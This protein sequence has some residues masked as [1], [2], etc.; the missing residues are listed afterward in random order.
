MKKILGILS[1]L[2]SG[3][4]QVGLADKLAITE[5]TLIPMEGPE[6][7]QGTILI[8]DGRIKAIK[9]L[10]YKVDGSYRKISAQGKFVIPGLFDSHIHFFQSGGLYT[11]PDGVDFRF[12]V[13]YKNQEFPQT[14]AGVDTTF[15]RYLASGV[16]SVVDMGG[17]MENFKVR[18]AARKSNTAPQVYVAGPLLST[19]SRDAMDVGDKP[20]VKVSNKTEADA[21][22]EKLAAQKPDFIKIWY[23][24]PNGG[25]WK[26]NADLVQ[27]IV[28]KSHTLGFRVA[29]HATELETARAAV[30]FGADVLVHSVEDK[31][32]DASFVEL[33][34]KKAV[35]YIPTLSVG[36]GYDKTF[37]QQISFSPLD[38][39]TADPFKMGTLFDLPQLP[40]D[41]IPA[42]VRKTMTERLPLELPKIAMQ[43]LKILVDAGV[44]IVTGTDAGNIG[45]FHGSAIFREMELMTLAGIEPHAVLR[46]SS[47]A[48]AQMLKVDNDL[49]S[50]RVGKLADLLILDRDPRKDIR[51]IQ[52]LHTVIKSGRP[53]LRS[54]LI[55][56]TP[57]AVVQSQLNAYHTGNIEAFASHFGPDVKFG[58]YGGP[59]KTGLDGIR[60]GW[61]SLFA[62]SEWIRL[63]IGQ[64]IVRENYVFDV[65]CGF[66]QP[67]DKQTEATSGAALYKVEN[68]LIKEMIFMPAGKDVPYPSELKQAGTFNLEEICS[69]G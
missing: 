43:N 44:P 32:V 24:I 22:V 36:E 61:G 7:Q 28:Q 54:E 50:I 4:S 38:Y 46:M 21:W 34:K 57:V 2:S 59:L 27:G 37:S 45:T 64:R 66:V 58:K 10:S 5:A 31:V 63:R 62:R 33:L 52:Y 19:I 1:L 13:S 55:P 30:Q 17:P 29:V 65:E 51:N 14:F 3:L 20:I 18:D 26:D 15:R 12:K 6:S 48:A 35:A 11:R 47:L 16:T 40:Y 23:I 25:S 49:G 41:A 60:E 69:K 39:E 67:K 53:F 42:R 8:E 56:K 68:G 9:D